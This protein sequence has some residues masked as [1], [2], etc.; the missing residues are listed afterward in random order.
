MLS[1]TK[2]TYQDEASVASVRVLSCTVEFVL[3]GGER[4]VS[5]NCGGATLPDCSPGWAGMVLSAFVLVS[6]T[7]CWCRALFI[8]QS[9]WLG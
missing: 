7:G 6:Q 8:I 9:S 2:R 4:R 1:L 5:L 3:L